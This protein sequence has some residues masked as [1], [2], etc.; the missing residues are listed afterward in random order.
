MTSAEEDVIMRRFISALVVVGMCASGSAV[1]AQDSGAKEETKKAGQATKE[2]GKDT[3]DAAKHIG[4]ATVKGTKKA[5][6]AVK[7]TIVGDDFK[8]TCND[9]TTYTGRSRED[10]CEKH[11][12]VRVW[13]KTKG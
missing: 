3:A 1:F 11:G 8:A 4:K 12:G 9:G 6:A 7:N 5:G 10:A 13:L 2:A